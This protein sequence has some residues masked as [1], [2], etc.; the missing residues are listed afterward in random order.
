MIDK[1]S[2]KDAICNDNF[3]FLEKHKSNY[4]IDERFEDEDNDTLLLYSISDESSKTYKFFLKE[5]ANIHLTNDFG[6]GIIHSVVYSGDLKRLKDITKNYS[7]NINHKAKD[8][9]TPLLLSISLKKKKLAE[10]LIMLGADV[11]LA[12]ENGIAPIHLVSQDNDKKFLK[13]LVENGSDVFFKTKKGNLPLA[14]AVNNGNY[15]IVTF[16]YKKTFGSLKSVTD[17]I[18]P[19]DGD[20]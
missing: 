18:E 9:V 2:L 15:D 16:L 13:L 5:N 6:E 12:D 20:R 10:Y 11:N 17:L 14:L 8:G 19:H 4:L 7:I 1:E 3:E